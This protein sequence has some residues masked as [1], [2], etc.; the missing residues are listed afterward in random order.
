MAGKYGIAPIRAGGV[1]GL[2]ALL[3][4]L[5]MLP[6]SAAAGVAEGMQTACAAIRDRAKMAAPGEIAPT[7]TSEVELEGT[8][9][10]GTVFV[11]PS[12]GMPVPEW[13]VFV[14]MGTGPKGIMSGGDKYPLPA[15]AYTQEPWVYHDE[16]GFHRTSGRFAQPYLWPAYEAERP[17]IVEY[18]GNN[19]LGGEGDT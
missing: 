3:A 14:E 18:I 6:E 9:V 13:P 4:K 2:D 19:I 7:I 12:G 8:L 10:L 16:N 11:D 17:Y 15:S 1:A 5:R